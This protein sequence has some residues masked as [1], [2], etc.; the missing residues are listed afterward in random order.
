MKVN[1]ET[2]EEINKLKDL[3]QDK[4]TEFIKKTPFSMKKVFLKLIAQ[5]QTED[6]LEEILDAYR[7][8]LAQTSGEEQDKIIKEMDYFIKMLKKYNK[9]K[10]RIS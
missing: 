5:K 10:H 9:L 7:L 8:K 4:Q 6:K 3:P 1:K 2:F